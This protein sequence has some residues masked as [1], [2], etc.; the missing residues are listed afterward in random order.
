MN[1][2]RNDRGFALPVAILALAL[3][4]VLVTG[5]FY[6]AYQETRIGVAA[7]RANDAFYLA[8]RGATE[9]LSEWDAPTFNAL[10]NWDSVTVQQATEEGQWEVTVTRMS[11]RF[12]FLRSTGTITTGSAVYGNATRT[13][14]IISHLST[15]EIMP[16]AALTTIGEVRI[17]G[18]M[19]II[20]HDTS[21]PGW[22]AFCD[23]VG[24][25]KPGILI[26]DT[27]NI[28]DIGN[29]LTVDGDP[30]FQQDTTLASDSLLTFGDLTF[31]ELKELAT[32]VYSPGS[33][34]R[35]LEPDSLP[36]G[37]GGYYCN[38]SLRDNWGTPLSPDGVCGTYFPIIYAQGDLDI[39]AN[40]AGQGILLV[41]GDLEISGTHVFY[42]PVIIKGTLWASG[43]GTG[44]HFRGG[45]VAAN[46]VLEDTRIT[47]NAVVE[48]SSCAVS[49]AI[50]NNSNLTRAHPLEDRSWVDLTAVMGG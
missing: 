48:F 32:I 37:T 24:P 26:D 38:S 13:L 45:V 20:G 25:S 41:E 9:V 11:S 42:G 14:G 43:G 12:F 28:R 33:R 5:G 6:V 16:K 36:D 17:Q 31:D 3:V 34:V 22:D 49:R 50:L 46:V 8:E 29:A 35:Q 19:E 7:H 44:G 23:S 10:S 39:A 40:E 18:S 15:A 4:G 47:G 2:T 21:P 30:D 1:R 27:L